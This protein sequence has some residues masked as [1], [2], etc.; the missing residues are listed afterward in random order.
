MVVAH[1]A[2]LPPTMMGRQAVCGFISFFTFRISIAFFLD[3]R[4]VNLN[5]P[6]DL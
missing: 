4:Y 2:V 5:I 6:K 1:G 3:K